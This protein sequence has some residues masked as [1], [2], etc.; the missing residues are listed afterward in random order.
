[1]SKNVKISS[2]K[3]GI[4][5]LVEKFSTWVFCF[6]DW[7]SFIC[8]VP[9]CHCLVNIDKTSVSDRPPI[10]LA[11]KSYERSIKNIFLLIWR[12]T[13]EGSDSIYFRKEFNLFWISLA[14]VGSLNIFFNF[15]KNI[16]CLKI[17]IEV[18]T[19]LGSYN[20]K[21]PSAWQ[22]L[23]P[24]LISSVIMLVLIKNWNFYWPARSLSKLLTTAFNRSTGK[25][26]K[27]KRSL[28]HL[29]SKGILSRQSYD[30]KNSFVILFNF[31]Y[32]IHKKCIRQVTTW[33]S[34]IVKTN[35]ATH[36]NNLKTKIYPLL[37]YFGDIYL[38]RQHTSDISIRNN[39][40]GFSTFLW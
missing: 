38:F 1:M 40:I 23:S 12:N 7:A 33:K 13:R 30:S 27:N 37:M 6:F 15:D 29:K 9:C 18:S 25:I 4:G 36:R 24:S 21:V 17:E 34:S 31:W 14:L 39:Q 32:P 35:T 28:I 26:V 10:G 2:W 16:F 22:T 8:E 5:V 19:A 20:D 11:E 3:P